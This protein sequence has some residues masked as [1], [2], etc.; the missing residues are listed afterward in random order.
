[1][2]GA[3]SRP[4]L[5]DS[6]PKGA[7]SQPAFNASGSL[8]K[9]T[10][11][12]PV[13]N[14]AILPEGRTRW[15]LF[16]AS[17][18]LECVILAALVILPILMPQKLEAV[19]RFVVTPMIEAPHISAWKPQPK[20]KLIPV[21]REIVKEIPKPEEVVVP[22]PKLYDPVVTAPVAR[23][24]TA[25]RNTPL[26]KVQVAEA[27]RNPLISTGSS[28]IPTLR[29]PRAE[30]QTGGFGDPE[31]LPSTKV[32][33]QVNINSAGSFDLPPGP[34]Y[35]NG[36]GGAK[37]A[38]GIIASSGFGNGVAI[39]SPNGGNRGVV[40][41]AGFANEAAAP[42]AQQGKRTQAASND[43]PVEVLFKPRPA[44]TAEARAKKIQG[45]VLLQV[46]FSADGTVEV[47]RVIR[48]LGYGLDA[49]AEQAAREIRFHPAVRNGQPVSYDAIVHIEFELAY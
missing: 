48:G 22:K 5:Y 17:F 3:M 24:A 2:K 33:R 40:Q 31:G 43:K 35:G 44:Y 11:S 12:R 20:P 39:G 49:S 25:R 4:V 18:G 42:V 6:L 23:R 19:R 47:Q 1:M 9:V 32:T 27:L 21:K 28:A 36:T 7:T 46:V 13:F 15:D 16:G 45:E 10:P 30:V 26:P 29:K 34:G 8:R 37:G 14:D 38:R 41:Q